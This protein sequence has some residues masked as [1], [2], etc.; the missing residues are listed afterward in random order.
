MSIIF[1]GT[2][3][4]AS[5]TINYLGTTIKEIVFDG[6]SVWKNVEVGAY[7]TLV[8]PSGQNNKN[9][10]TIPLS[11]S[12]QTSGQKTFTFSSNKLKVN[13]SCTV[14]F[15]ISFNSE[16]WTENEDW[17]SDLTMYIKQVRNG[18]T[19]NA[20]S[21]FWYVPYNAKS[22]SMSKT[23][24]AVSGDEFYLYI[25]SGTCG[26]SFNSLTMKATVTG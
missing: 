20:A 17:T 6:V 8:L 4:P 18:T 16:A 11:L 23:I 25:T 13:T 10:F 12:G 19:S 22:F 14:K 7:M 3:L 15:D 2:T 24:N 5:A 26:T 9:N 1:N 21:Q